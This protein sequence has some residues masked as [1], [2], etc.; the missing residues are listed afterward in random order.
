MA[1]RTAGMTVLAAFHL[2]IGALGVL[3]STLSILAALGLLP[4]GGA[5]LAG[6]RAALVALASA[7]L[8]ISALLVAAGIGV[9]RL[10]PSART[11]SVAAAVAW[12]AVNLADGLLFPHAFGLRLVW[13][14][15]YSVL[16]LVLFARPAW[17]AAFSADR[18]AGEAR[19]PA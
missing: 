13:G 4:V 17:R 5:P 19:D 11:L 14:T 12:I 1:T 8:A 7:R 15:L 18:S 2:A 9:L 16:V 6:G 10:R 3:G